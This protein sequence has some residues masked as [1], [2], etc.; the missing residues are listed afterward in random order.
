MRK[1]TGPRHQQRI[2]IPSDWNGEDWFCVQL[3]WPNSP[4]WISILVGI[5][6][7]MT[8]GWYWNEQTGTVTDAQIIGREIFLR[9]IGFTPC[10]TGNGSDDGAGNAE[11]C[12]QSSGLA[13]FD[14][15]ECDEM[16]AVTWLDYDE[17]GNLRMWFGPCCS[18]L[19]Q[20]TTQDTQ[21]PDPYE[22]QESITYT[23]CGKA[24]ALVEALWSVLD[25]GWD[26]QS[27]A[28]PFT[29]VG[30]VEAALPGYNLSDTAIWSLVQ[31]SV[32]L[33]NDYSKAEVLTD[34]RKQQLK[35]LASAIFNDQPGGITQTEY[36]QWRGLSAVVFEGEQRQWAQTGMEAIGKGNSSNIAAL[37]AANTDADCTCP[38]VP[39]A[40][41]GPTASGW[42]LEPMETRQ[43]DCIGGFGYTV[44]FFRQSAPHDTYGAVMWF[45]RTGGAPLN[46]AKRGNSCNTP[47]PDVCFSQSNSDN[48][49][50]NISYCQMG[51][52]AY[53]E[54]SSLLASPTQDKT[55]NRYSDN[56]ASPYADQGDVIEMPMAAQAQG[57]EEDIV[58]MEFTIWWLR[59]TNSPSHS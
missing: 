37:G 39:G 54:L 12:P 13:S 55:I 40:I 1:T 52:G 27:S 58:N 53:A 41:V 18:Q 24:D 22:D 34:Y 46:R 43:V 7:N 47:S 51:D 33:D 20:G 35:C 49:D 57:D 48:W 29:W 42:Y 6:S 2:P 56:V 15:Q 14:E 38:A 5:L 50:E 26:A 9:N 32:D 31:Q 44:E 4:E 30:V 23:S 25:A 28:N 36:D 17:N 59:N 19:V 45:H 16:P 11:P 10:G 8:R 21:L 3:Q